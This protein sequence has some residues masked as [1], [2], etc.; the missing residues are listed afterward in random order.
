M[1]EGT[2]R[3]IRVDVTRGVALLSMFVAHTAPDLPFL[4]PVS[5][6]AD[7]LTAALFA[8]LIG[9]GTMLG[10]AAHQISGRTTAGY[11]LA[12]LIRA[13]C[14]FGLGMITDELGAQVVGILM[15]LALLSLLCALVAP[16]PGWGVATVGGVALV[17]APVLR[18]EFRERYLSLPS[19]AAQ[20][21]TWFWDLAGGGFYYQTPALLV[22]GCAGIIVIR[23]QRAG[24]LSR[25][26]AG[27]G[28]TALLVTVA[29]VLG[30]SRL[31]VLQVE[32]YRGDLLD[33]MTNLALAVGVLLLCLAL[34]GRV[35]D[36]CRP[37]AWLGAMT[38]TLYVLHHVFLGWWVGPGGHPGDNSWI[39]LSVLTFGAVLIASGWRSLRLGGPFRR[40]PLEGLVST[41]SWPARVRSE[42]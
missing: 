6:V 20:V 29:V 22:W 32:A 37:L 26:R 5:V 3:D 35:A 34:P 23:A 42:G 28:A 17:A 40:G 19:G 24:R 15:H 2:A 9:A 30:A 10:R 36:L 39:T 18:D 25:R 31:G 11:V 27:L 21:Q 7:H 13:A 1:T 14:L 41:L 4:R 38:L 16:L 12:V 8:V 33:I